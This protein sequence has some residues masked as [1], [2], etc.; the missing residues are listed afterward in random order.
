MKLSGSR[1]NLQIKQNIEKKYQVLKQ[2]KH[3]QSNVI[4]QIIIIKSEV[5]YAFTRNKSYAYLLNVEPNNIV[6][7]KTHNTEFDTITI[8]STD[9]NGRPLEVEDKV[10]LTLLIIKYK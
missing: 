2:L 6:F 3:F 1:K 4:Q 7:L 9:Q 8:T 10:N 5:L